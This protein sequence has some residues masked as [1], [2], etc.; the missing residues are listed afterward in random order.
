MGGEVW[1]LTLVLT[2][3]MELRMGLDLLV[4]NYKN[5]PFVQSVSWKGLFLNCKCHSELCQ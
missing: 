3:G 4:V 1:S 2:S 5:I